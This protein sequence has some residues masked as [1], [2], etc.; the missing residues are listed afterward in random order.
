LQALLAKLYF[1]N[2]CFIR[3]IGQLMPI[4]HRFLLVHSIGATGA[5]ESGKPFERAFKK[6]AAPRPAKKSK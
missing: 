5:D 6:I 3:D 4:S 1:T 2:S